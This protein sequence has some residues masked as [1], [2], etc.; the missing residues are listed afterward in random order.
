MSFKFSVPSIPANWCDEGGL[1][2]RTYST[3][4]GGS[5]SPDPSGLTSGSLASTSGSMTEVS[6][7]SLDASTT[8]VWRGYFNPDAT[9]STWEFR[10]TSG[11]GAYLWLDSNAETPVAS[12][13]TANAIVDNSG[14]HGSQ[15]ATSTTLSLDSQYHYALTLIAG[16]DTG[17]GEVTLEWRRDGGAWASD[18]TSR[19]CHDTRYVDGFGA[20]AYTGSAGGG[21]PAAATAS[22]WAVV[23]DAGPGDVS[24]ASN[25]DR[26]SWTTYDRV[27]GNGNA[28]A[29][30][31]GKDSS[32]NGIFISSNGSSTGELTVSTDNITDGSQWTKINFAGTYTG[33]NK[34]NAIAWGNDSSN[35]TSGVWLV[36]NVVGDLWR[37]TNGGTSYSEI[38]LPSQTTSIIY[39]IAANG[40]GKFVTAQDNRLLV[41][42][43][44]GASFTAS[45]PFTADEINGVAFTNSTWIVTYTKSNESNLFLRTAA[46]SDLTT[47]SS[48]VD[49][50]IAKPAT[51]DDGDDVWERANI[52]AAS[53]RAVVVANK[54]SAV[55]ILDVNGT[56]TSNLS[57][58]SFGGSGIRD[59]TTDG[60]T[61]M[62]V[63]A[64]GDIYESTN[65][66]GSWSQTV[67]DILTGT[68][69][70][71]TNIHAV[72]A[73]M[74]LPL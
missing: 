8:R 47:W 19:L 38:S 58:P 42:T 70:A 74:Y 17:D 28:Q 41:S 30:A 35:S 64:G 16:N 36:G 60:N 48:E 51:R 3:Y 55:A 29:M 15:T 21:S 59:I 6:A 7:S 71:G 65:N 1:Y 11:D 39:S 66:G 20:D 4:T 31:Y 45:T 46:D 68:A 9:S 12:L 2:Y 5:S 67:D 23:Y 49:L 53:G 25:S 43:D 61:W 26:T 24:Y 33:G 22:Y 72:A 40:S 57:N 50:G 56:S 37:S 18:G 13:N 63:G 52:A 34:F 14:V 73:S 32:G 54:G 44:D 27:G 69:N 62:I 10:V